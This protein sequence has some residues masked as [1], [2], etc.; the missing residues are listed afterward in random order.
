MKTYEVVIRTF[1]GNEKYYM[2]FK[3][4]KEGLKDF[5]R[6]KSSIQEDEE[7]IFR[8]YK[9]NETG[10]VDFGDIQV[11]DNLPELE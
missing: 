2:D 3:T 8:W 6:L 7:M 1:E 10:I 9:T 4:K 11:Y 5:N